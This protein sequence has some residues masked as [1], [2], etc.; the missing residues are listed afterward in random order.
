MKI[1]CSRLSCHFL[2]TM[3]LLECC[4]RRSMALFKQ[5]VRESAVEVDWDVCIHEVRCKTHNN[6]IHAHAH[7]FV[8]GMLFHPGRNRRHESKR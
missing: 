1:N 2:Q 6:E 7:S 8:P 5:L 3:R 4:D